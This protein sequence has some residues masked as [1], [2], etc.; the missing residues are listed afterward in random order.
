MSA[1]REVTDV[2]PGPD[3]VLHGGPWAGAR[4]GVASYVGK[5]SAMATAQRLCPHRCTLKRTGKGEKK[6]GEDFV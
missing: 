3:L 1:H 6:K 4:D 2:L 5:K